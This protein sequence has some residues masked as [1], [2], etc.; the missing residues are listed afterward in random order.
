MLENYSYITPEDASQLKNWVPTH[1]KPYMFFANPYLM[2]E[3]IWPR[4]PCFA[5]AIS[6]YTNSLEGY[7]ALEKAI[8]QSLPPSREDLIVPT[9]MNRAFIETNTPQK[10]DIEIFSR[11]DRHVHGG[12]Y[13]GIYNGE[14]SVLSK[15]NVGILPLLVDRESDLLTKYG[16]DVKRY[17][18]PKNPTVKL[19]EIFLLRTG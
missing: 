10:G 3:D 11:W 12:I 18:T 6:F 8:L 9:I 2:D 17:F 15:A 13:I 14:P 5:A 16:A 19:E 4:L 1:L 7:A